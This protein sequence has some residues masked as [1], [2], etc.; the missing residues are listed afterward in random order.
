MPRSKSSVTHRART[1]KILKQSKGY[2]GHRKNIL[3][4]AKQSVLRSGMY[5]FAHRRKKKGDYRVLWQIRI[6]A[7]L[8]EL[9][10]YPYSKLIQY[11]KLSNI[12][13]DRKVLAFLAVNDLDGFKQVAIEAKNIAEKNKK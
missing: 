9:E 4:V 7:A 13:L 6:N 12:Q 5:A 11:M 1:K 10:L 3:S 8:R 2:Y